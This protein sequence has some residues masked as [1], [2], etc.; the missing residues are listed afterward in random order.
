[1]C[2]V[3][4]DIL[5]MPLYTQDALFRIAASLGKNNF[6]VETVNHR[7][8]P[9]TYDISRPNLPKLTL[10][11]MESTGVVHVGG[12]WPTDLVRRLQ[13]ELPHPELLGE[14]AYELNTVSVVDDTHDLTSFWFHSVDAAK[15]QNL[16][17]LIETIFDI[18]A[19]RRSGR[20]LASS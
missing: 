10:Y 11:C 4:L 8:S 20:V 6:T 12:V 13:T 7:D 3:D 2:T 14:Q 15:N 9:P 18:M 1:M 19:R 5:W 16:I 17:K